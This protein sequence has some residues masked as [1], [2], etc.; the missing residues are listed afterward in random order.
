M[1]SYR[2]IILGIVVV[3]AILVIFLLALNQAPTSQVSSDTQANIQDVKSDM[4]DDGGT[5][6]LLYIAL[7]GMSLA[8]LISVAV[9]FYLYKWR[10]ILLA[11]PELLVPEEWGR[12]I[13]SLGKSVR[14]LDQTLSSNIDY[15]GS[16]T[17]E[18]SVKITNMTET[19]MSLQSVLDEKD[20]TIRRLNK[21]YDAEIFRKFLSRFIRI[22]QAIDDYINCKEID[23]NTLHQLKRLFEDAL[24]ECGVESFKPRIGVDYRREAGIA[25]HP[26]KVETDEPEKDFMVVEVIESG[27]RLRNGN[28]YEIIRPSK[29]SIYRYEE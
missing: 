23:S 13:D 20:S 18:A 11:R 26:K 6:T 2:T 22:D 24:D 10:K 1:K 17:S 16:L 9:S 19:Y 29:V 14:V 21:G 12:Y 15:L 27:Y 25:D 4:A 8:T 7:I 5:D 28:D 3:V